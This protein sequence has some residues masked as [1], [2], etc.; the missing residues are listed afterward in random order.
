MLLIFTS[1]FCYFKAPLRSLSHSS[2]NVPFVQSPESGC[3]S[4]CTQEKAWE[5]RMLHEGLITLLAIESLYDV[6]DGRLDLTN[7]ELRENLRYSFVSN[8]V[9]EFSRQL[10]GWRPD[11]A[12][13]RYSM[14]KRRPTSSKP[15]PNELIAWCKGL[16]KV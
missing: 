5:L 7:P 6:Q 14:S 12:H 2:D 8:N 9:A 13:W 3:Q 11:I 10:V 16:G 1:F 4:W 15:R